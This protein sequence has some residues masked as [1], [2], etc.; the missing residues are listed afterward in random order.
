MKA[1][2]SDRAPISE[3]H[4][5]VLFR[6]GWK[7]R[8][9]LGSLAAGGAFAGMPNL[10]VK[11]AE[12]GNASGFVFHDQD[13]DGRRGVGDKGIGGVMVSNGRDVVLTD[14]NGKWQLPLLEGKSTDF[15]V[16]K[17]GGWTV[18]TSPDL[19]PLHYYIHQPE[20]S[21][22]QRYAGFKPTGALPESIDFPLIENEES[23]AFRMLICGD[24]QPRDQREVD[25]IA[26]STPAALRDAKGDLGLTLGDVAFDNLTIYSSLNKVFASTGI[27]WRH[28]LGNHD[29]NFDSKDDTFANETFRSVYGPTYYS[30]DHGKVHF[31]VLNNI[32]WLGPDPDEGRERGRYHGELGEQQ[33]QWL[34]ADLANV[35]K[36]HLV[37]L[38][39][40][41]PLRAE[42]GDPYWGSTSDRK[43]LFQLLK[44]HPHTISF[45]AHRHYHRH[46]FIMEEGW[47]HP[48][49]HHHLSVGALCGAWFRGAPDVFDVPHGI[50]G[51]GTP[52]G[53]IAADFD[54]NV[55]KIDGYRV[56]GAPASKQMHIYLP[57]YEIAAAAAGGMPFH[58]NF[59]NGSERSKLKARLSS[60][61]QWRELERVVEPDPLYVNLVEQ[62][63]DLDSPWRTMRSNPDA[64]SHLWKGALP[65]GLDAGAHVIEVVAEDGFGHSAHQ[66]RIIRIKA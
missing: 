3:G 4:S 53:F 5:E 23:D 24:P 64:C 10:W 60:G 62:E 54:G 21:P 16:V 17:P 44:N 41:I 63:G 28:V 43:E 1:T 27:P 19:L 8:K 7:R 59:Y 48:E 51:D 46:D 12:A 40:H 29:L 31:V 42:S 57:S 14:E 45:S 37:V 49:P 33:R 50:M 18:P 35:P 34:E 52:R 32:R 25:Y 13:G 30:F 39:L 26:Q 15:F 6:G 20:G 65:E 61:D 36:D 9:F 38:F 66:S 55:C 22:E 58:V 56:I 2:N 11:A 47:A